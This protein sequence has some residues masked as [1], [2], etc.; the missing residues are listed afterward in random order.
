MYTAGD[1]KK[2]IEMFFEVRMKAS[3]VNPVSWSTNPSLNKDQESAW[4]A[5]WA[6]RF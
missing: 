3:Q 2:I 5:S 4:L 6:L 1:H